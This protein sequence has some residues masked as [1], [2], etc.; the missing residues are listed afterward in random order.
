MWYQRLT[1]MAVIAVLLSMSVTG[2]AQVAPRGGLSVAEATPSAD[3]KP[4]YTVIADS[5]PINDLLRN[6]FKKTGEQ[7]SIDQDVY[8]P[9]DIVIKNATVDEILARICEASHPPLRIERGAFT[10]VIAVRHS[11]PIASKSV[12]FA[13]P[14]ELNADAAHAG[15]PAPLDRPVTLLIPDSRPV[16]LAQGLRMI[17]QQVQ[18][19]IVLDPSIP[20]QARFSARFQQTSLS[21]VLD[22]L[23]KTGAFQWSVTSQGAIL[24]AP[25]DSLRIMFGERALADHPCARCKHPLAAAWRYCPYCGLPVSRSQR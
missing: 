2:L 25:R 6:L 18:V 12:R 10:R 16:S 13:T 9:V 23:A 11:E 4:R 19:P 15:T 17:S 21:L 20:G 8:G 5:V 24:I 14:T 22:S 3:G 1:K 7:Y